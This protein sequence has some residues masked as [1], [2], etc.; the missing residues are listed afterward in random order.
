MAQEN[1]T[2]KSITADYESV[3]AQLETMRVDMAKMAHNVSQIA[4]RRSHDMAK[5]M[6]E[7]MSDA[8]QYLGRK[9]HEADMRVEGAVAANPY[10]ALGLAAG[11]G[12]LL[13]ALTRR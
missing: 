6:T 9:G 11:V 8:A 2:P 7:G 4:S 10:L 12:A 1:H 13:G 5:D 3:L